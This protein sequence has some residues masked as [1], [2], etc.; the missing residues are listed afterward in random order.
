MYAE[1]PAHKPLAGYTPTSSFRKVCFL[2]PKQPQRKPLLQV[3][4]MR[5]LGGAI[6]LFHI[7]NV[8]R[9]IDI[10]PT[11]S[12]ARQRTRSTCHTMCI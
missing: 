2:K 12:L 9:H 10:E 1:R 5:L 11:Q 7:A 4:C 3:G 8:F 6:I